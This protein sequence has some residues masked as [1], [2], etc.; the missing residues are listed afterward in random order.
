MMRDANWATDDPRRFRRRRP[1]VA[2]FRDRPPVTER[3]A[4]LA[5]RLTGLAMRGKLATQHFKTL[6]QNFGESR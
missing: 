2:S 5:A 4:G 6:F 3:A 1:S